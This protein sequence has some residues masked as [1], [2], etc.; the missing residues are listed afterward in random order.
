[1][2]A[3]NTDAADN[4]L[5]KMAE[6]YDKAA[7]SNKPG[8]K[9]YALMACS[10]RVCGAV[11]AGTACDEEVVAQLKIIINA[12]PPE[13]ADFCQ[14]I[15]WADARTNDVILHSE[16]PAGEQPSLEEAYRRAWRQARSPVKLRL[17]AE[18]LTF[19]EDI[20]SH[21]DEKTKLKRQ[22]IITLAQNLRSTLEAEFLEGA[23]T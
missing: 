22:S 13:D 15:R 23:S 11:R 19:Y 7:T 6:C 18:H 9:S 17:N 3:A 16:D 20:F 12:A 21:G 1:V 5:K 8:D 14:L 10:A 2:Q 4:A